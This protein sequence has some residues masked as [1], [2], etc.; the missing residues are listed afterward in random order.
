M[1]DGR[2]VSQMEDLLAHLVCADAGLG[3]GVGLSKQYDSALPKMRSTIHTQVDGGHLLGFSPMHPK[4]AY[5]A[6]PGSDRLLATDPSM[7]L[8]TVQDL[9]GGRFEAAMVDEGS[10]KW[11]GVKRLRKAPKNSWVASPRAS[12]YE[13]H[14]RRV[15]A[16]GQSTYI[17][18]LGA[19]DSKGRNVPAQT[20]GC[21]SHRS[22]DDLTV[23]QQ[24]CLFASVK[25][26]AHRPGVLLARFTEHASVRVPVPLGEHKEMFALRDAPMTRA[27][28]RKAILHWVTKHLRERPSLVDPSTI[29][30]HW[31]GQRT[32]QME[33]MSIELQPNDLQTT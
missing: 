7:L 1:T 16:T 15:F 3:E 19:L 30:A 24:L 2:T 29:S 23:G 18:A 4:D 31:R 22:S 26:D 11:F 5:T 33:G 28:R 10:V 32:I 8:N 25:E 14:Y 12:L 20:V 13:V 17:V 6:I 21:R 27:G 9:I